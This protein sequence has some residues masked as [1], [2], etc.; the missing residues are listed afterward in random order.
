MTYITG[1]GDMHP[2][3]NYSAQRNEH[4][5]EIAVALRTFAS[6]PPT[7]DRLRL[8]ALMPVALCVAAHA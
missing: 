7:P 2:V 3:C 8:T 6:N 4:G 5:S 1:S